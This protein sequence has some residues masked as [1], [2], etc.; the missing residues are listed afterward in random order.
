MRF[1]ITAL[2][3]VF[4][5]PV[6]SADDNKPSPIAANV[7]ITAT[8]TSLTQGSNVT[9]EIKPGQDVLEELA[10]ALKECKLTVIK[11]DET[12]AVVIALPPKGL[13]STE[14]GLAA[15]RKDRLIVV[16]GI[17]TTTENESLL[18]SCG[19]KGIKRVPLLIAK[20]ATWVNDKNKDRFPSENRLTIRG[21][22]RKCEI[23]IGS[24]SF[25]WAIENA[26]GFIPILL[27]KD[28]KVPDAGT[29]VLVS[30]NLRVVDGRPV[31]KSDKIEL[32]KE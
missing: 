20:T 6:N 24:E 23:K 3:L 1:L 16:E 28:A 5:V 26:D 19:I 9:V 11:P 4:V 17:L 12:T 31:V 22:A 18:K 7:V 8:P 2:A 25:N 21:V 29:T 15:I 14:L 13:D 32:A 30:G 27:A 10:K